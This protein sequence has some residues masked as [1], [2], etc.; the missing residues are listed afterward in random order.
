MTTTFTPASILS[1]PLSDEPEPGLT[2][3]RGHDSFPSETHLSA[4][5]Q[6]SAF[7]HLVE[8]LRRREG[9]NSEELAFESNL[10]PAVI[11]QIEE[12]PAY[13]PAPS[14]VVQIAKV[15]GLTTLPLF[16]LAGL[17]GSKPVM[18]HVKTVVSASPS[19]RTG[20][21]SREERQ[22]LDEWLTGFSSRPLRAAA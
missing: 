7:G 19:D 10:D 8:L 16:Q 9:W 11:L 17:T 22:M 18:S 14:T 1:A 4:T 3:L 21:L 13:R 2:A 20:R 15:F 5:P 6:R 12:V